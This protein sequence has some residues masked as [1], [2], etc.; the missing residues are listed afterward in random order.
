MRH[1][2]W[3]AAF[4]LPLPFAALPLL[5]VAFGHF[6]GGN[7]DRLTLNATPVQM[8][9]GDGPVAPSQPHSLAYGITESSPDGCLTAS[10][11]TIEG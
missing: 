9:I 6:D 1:K 3:I 11:P 5:A 7:P 8:Q 2:S 4:L 10:N